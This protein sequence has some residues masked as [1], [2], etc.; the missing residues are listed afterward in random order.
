[1]PV[2]QSFPVSIG[3]CE[4]KSKSQLKT[5]MKL[6]KPIIQS[7]DYLIELYGLLQDEE[8]QSTWKQKY[9]ERFGA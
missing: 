5:R 1:M 3:S 6:I 4:D 9:A 2:K 8:Q 7:Y